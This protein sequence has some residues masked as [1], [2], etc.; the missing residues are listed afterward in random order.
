M[1][2]QG[3][4]T[5]RLP[6]AIR[7]ELPEP[8]ASKSRVYAKDLPPEVLD[9]VYGIFRNALENTFIF[10]LGSQAIVIV[11]ANVLARALRANFRGKWW[12][13]LLV[14]LPWVAPISLGTI[15]WKWIYDSIYSVINWTGQA[16]HI[17]GPDDWPMWLGEPMPTD[18]LVRLTLGGQPV[19]KRGEMLHSRLRYFDLD[20]KRPGLPQGVAA[21]VSAITWDSVEVEFVNTNLFEPRSLILQAGAY[22]EDTFRTVTMEGR[23]SSNVN[24][25]YFSLTLAPGAGA[26]LKIQTS[27][28]QN[29]PR[30]SFPWKQ[31]EAP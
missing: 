15:G 28:Y 29:Q 14:L 22:G 21:L 8:I 18:N 30:Y 10:T 23:E 13:R 1:T 25:S 31:T 11:L 27:R 26:K 19:Q 24:Q 17:L 5:R 6:K 7:E 16:L 12:L 2:G 3:T 9:A 4:E 20:R